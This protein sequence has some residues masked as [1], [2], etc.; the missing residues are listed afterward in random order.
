M[1]AGQ[2]VGIRI[3]EF[4]TERNMTLN[5]LSILC[6]VNQST[7]NNVVNGVSK[8]PT[9][10]TVKKVCDGLEITLTQFFDADVFY[11]LDQE[12]E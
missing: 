1:K 11:R 5:K 2:A 8:N 4:C 7:L 9:V 3:R 12:I 6:G 10:A